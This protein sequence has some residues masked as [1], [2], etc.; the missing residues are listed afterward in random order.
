MSNVESSYAYK[1]MHVFPYNEDDSIASLRRRSSGGP[2]LFAAAETKVPSMS[3]IGA[4]K[5]Q[6]LIEHMDSSG[7]GASSSCGFWSGRRRG[8][9]PVDVY[10]GASGSCSSESESSGKVSS[11]PA[12]YLQIKD[13]ILV[14]IVFT[15]D[16]M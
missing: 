1:W 7:G 2:E 15:V 3:T 12:V 14:T 5:A 11:K 9:L 16:N 4:W 10:A 6:I 8:S 13:V